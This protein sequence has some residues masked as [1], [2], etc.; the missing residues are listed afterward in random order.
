[1]P[2]G[3]D[4]TPAAAV[5]AR[6]DVLFTEVRSIEPL[7]EIVMKKTTNEKKNETKS[8][9]GEKPAKKTIKVLRDGDILAV[10]GGGTVYTEQY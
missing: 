3:A 8:A 1:L 4:G 2:P 7:T 5:S 6:R 9:K 10:Q